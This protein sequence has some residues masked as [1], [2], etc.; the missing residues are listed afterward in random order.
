MINKQKRQKEI[1][2][3]IARENGIPIMEAEEIWKLFLNKIAETISEP[4]KKNHEGH[5]A[6][7][8]FKT[9]HID[10]FGKFHVNKNN[11]KHANMCIRG[12]TNKQK[13][14]KKEDGT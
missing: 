11:L 13:E 10:N 12:E 7:S 4:D 1:L 3:R 9:I 5:Y 2:N 8:K 14:K 6:E